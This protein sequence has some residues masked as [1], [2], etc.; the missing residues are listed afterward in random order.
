METKAELAKA[1]IAVMNDVAG[2]EKSLTVGSGNSSYKGVSDKDV[3]RIIGSAMAKHGLC[4]LPIDVDSK[5]TIERWEE[6]DNYSKQMKTKQLVFDEVNTKYLLLHTSGESQ[7]IAGHG[8][9]VDSQDKSAGKATTYALKNALLYTF[10]IPTGDIDDADK[11]HSNDHPIPKKAEPVK[12][13]VAKSLD[14]R[15]EDAKVELD[16][17]ITSPVDFITKQ[18]DFRFTP[19]GANFQ[20]SASV[21]DL[22]KNNHIDLV[23]SFYKFVTKK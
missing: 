8:H 13:S 22:V 2:I 23:L 14:K 10:M 21:A 12:A 18:K 7:V 5:T 17:V 11:T 6:M 20:S 16:K 4:I 9:G 1:I 3:K 19:E 15:L